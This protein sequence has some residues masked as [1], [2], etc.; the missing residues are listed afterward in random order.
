MEMA[1][2]A[3]PKDGSEIV[4]AII[5]DSGSDPDDNDESRNDWFV[6]RKTAMEHVYF[7]EEKKE[8]VYQDQVHEEERYYRPKPRNSG[9]EM[10]QVAVLICIAVAVGLVFKEKILQFVDST[11]DGLFRSGF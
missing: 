3:I 8:K 2:R 6:E 11:F 1:G 5:S 10:V 7:E 4:R 9:M